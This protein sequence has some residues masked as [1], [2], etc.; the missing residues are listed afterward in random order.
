VLFTVEKKHHVIENMGQILL[1][2]SFLC[3]I[4]WIYINVEKQNLAKQSRPKQRFAIDNNCN[5]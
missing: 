3:V 4:L 1:S 5:L 2:V